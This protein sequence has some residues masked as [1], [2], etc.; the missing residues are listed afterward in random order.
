MK[1]NDLSSSIRRTL[2]SGAVEPVTLAE[3]KLN[4]RI[5]GNTEDALVERLIAAARE[6]VEGFCVRSFVDTECVVTLSGFPEDAI[7]LYHG[8]VREVTEISYMPPVSS[9][10]TRQVV[11][12]GSWSHDLNGRIGLINPP[13]GGWP[14]ALNL[15]G[16]VI[17]KYK[18]G[19]EAANTEEEVP[20][21]VKTAM[22][23]LI[24]N[25]YAN[26]SSV[27]T[28]ANATE[29]PFGVETLLQREAC[30]FLS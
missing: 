26:R 16:S 12:L 27:I 20:E 6:T 30:G 14:A 2:A 9:G 21:A 11:T 23:L 4:S 1:F 10:F 17:I 7:K 13:T 29:L 18:A 8:F 25:L 19:P 24:E 5:A 15:P 28:G 22:F 3:A